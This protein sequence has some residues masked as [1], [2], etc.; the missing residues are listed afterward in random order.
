MKIAVTGANGTLG[1]ELVKWGCIPI[2][3]DITNPELIRNEIEYINPDIL[4]HCAA[5]TNVAFCESHF[6]EAFEVNVRGT[7]NVISSLPPSATMIYL[8]TDHVF[9]GDNW[10]N[11]GYGEWH[12]PSPVNY[13]GYTK[14]GGEIVMQTGLCH[15]LIIRTSRCYDYAWMK[16]TLDK[17]KNGE[18]VIFTNL[19]KRSFMY[20]PYM[21][22]SLM[23][24]TDNLNRIRN[25]P[26]L[27][28]SGESVF[29]YYAFWHIVHEYLGLPGKIIPRNEKVEDSPRPFRAGLDTRQA[30]KFGVPMGSLSTALKEIK[31]QMKNE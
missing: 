22:D 20:L 13:Y 23:W 30:K 31:E 28:V 2:D 8:S 14:W 4:I 3:V 6:K 11:A 26:V 1:R 5:L 9:P 24:I 16:P 15:T 10:F 27:H 7:S 21:V 18:E 19:I 29:S 25:E 17:L 12:K